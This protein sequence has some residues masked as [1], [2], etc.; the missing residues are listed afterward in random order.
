MRAAVT[1][2]NDEIRGKRITTHDGAVGTIPASCKLVLCNGPVGNDIAPEVLRL[3]VQHDSPIGYHPYTRYANGQRFADDWRDDSGRWHFMEQSAG[4]KPEWVF[5]ECGPY[6]GVNEGWRHPTVLDAR[7]EAL[8]AAMR[9]WARDVLGTPA[10]HEGRLLGW[11]GAWFTVGG[12][13]H[14][15]WYELQA[16]QLKSLAGM[17]AE[18]WKPQA[19]GAGAVTAPRLP[20]HT[21]PSIDP[22]GL[23]W[24][25]SWPEGILNPTRRLATPPVLIQMCRADGTAIDGLKRRNGMDVWE[26]RGALLRV[27]DSPINGQLWWVRANDVQPE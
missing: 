15:P 18:E 25:E 10:Y 13:G 7:S 27:L 1:A 21:E 20:G 23:R 6:A 22:A 2:W 12:G 17:F 19:V 3:G 16:D 11:T 24:W 26:R 9:A 14:W 4:I 5:T 8:V